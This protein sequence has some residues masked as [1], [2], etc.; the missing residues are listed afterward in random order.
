MTNPTVDPHALAAQVAELIGHESAP[1]L[2]DAEQAGRLLNV[3]VSWMLAQARAGRVPPCAPRATSALIGT[4][5]SRSWIEHRLTGPR[6]R[7]ERLIALRWQDVDR[8]ARR[9]RVRRSHVLGEFDTPKSRRSERS[10]PL[11]RR[12]ASELD[13]W[14]WRPGGGPP[15]TTSCSL[16]QRLATCCVAAR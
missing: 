15:R 11:S 7:R 16:S 2:L 13:D 5:F 10:V 6:A 8:D 12:V 14:R 4:S 3:P 9:L 1:R